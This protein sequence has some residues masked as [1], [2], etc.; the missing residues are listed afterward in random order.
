VVPVKRSSRTL[1][2]GALLVA[3]AL[4]ALIPQG[5]MPA[6]GRPFSLEICWQGLPAAMLAHAEPAD[7]GTMDMDSM[8]GSMHD[9]MH[10]G[11]MADTMSHPGLPQGAHGHTGHPSSSDYCVFGAAWSP[12][13]ITHFPQPSDFSF[14]PPLRAVAFVSIAD[15]IRLVYLPQSRAPPGRLS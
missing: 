5:F 15:A 8:P 6:S 7:T 11:A 12:G 13:P 4:R 3:F 14:P 10:Q 9:S 2:A 1:I